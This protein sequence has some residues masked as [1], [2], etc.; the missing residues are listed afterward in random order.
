MQQQHQQK[1][2]FPSFVHTLAFA[3]QKSSPRLGLGRLGTHRVHRTSSSWSLTNLIIVR[4]SSLLSFFRDNLLL[5]CMHACRH[6]RLTLEK[7]VWPERKGGKNP[8][9]FLMPNNSAKTCK[10]KLLWQLDSLGCYWSV[11][12]YSRDRLPACL[13]ACL[14]TMVMKPDWS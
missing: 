4:I 2:P 1:S 9:S 13:P 3:D 6:V 5:E 7:R 14:P 10:N 12:S 11:D 8:A